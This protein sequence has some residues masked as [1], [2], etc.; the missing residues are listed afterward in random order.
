MAGQVDRHACLDRKPVLHHSAEVVERHVEAARL[1]NNLDV[2]MD[3]DTDKVTGTGT[4]TD[5]DA[6]TGT[7]AE[8]V[9]VT[10]TDTGAKRTPKLKERPAL[11]GRA[12]RSS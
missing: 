10:V 1:A 9:T 8:K 12:A 5:T 2:W 11:Q 3:S 7:D 6:G 4:G